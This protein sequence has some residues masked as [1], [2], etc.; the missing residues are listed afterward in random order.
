MLVTTRTATPLGDWVCIEG[1]CQF[2]RQKVAEMVHMHRNL[3]DKAVAEKFAPT[4]RSIKSQFD[5]LNSSWSTWVPFHTVCCRIK[6]VGVQ[7][8]EITQQMATASGA[9]A[10]KRSGAVDPF[11]P[12]QGPLAPISTLIKWGTGILVVGG[13]VF[14]GIKLYGVARAEGSGSSSFP[15]PRR[16]PRPHRE[17]LEEE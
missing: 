13:A 4:V 2:G 7:A 1:D 5:D 17:A 10:P 9:P 12:G 16:R 8:E 14:V 15:A 3:P 11:R 6:S